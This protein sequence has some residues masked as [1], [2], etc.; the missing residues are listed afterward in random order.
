MKKLFS[1]IHENWGLESKILLIGILLI[2]LY[3][4]ALLVFLWMGNGYFDKLLSVG[5]TSLVFGRAAGISLALA[6]EVDF[7]WAM[8][9]NIYIENAL[10]LVVYPLFVWSVQGISTFKGGKKFFDSINKMAIKYEKPINKYG[11]FG[12][13]VF[14]WL[15]FW[16]TGPIVGAAIGY[17]MKLK[18]WVNLLVVLGGTNIAIFC[19]GY[20]LSH[21]D[22]NFKYFGENTI[23]VLLGVFI[24]LAL[25]GTIYTKFIKKG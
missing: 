14:V 15:P 17:F 8:V 16:M 20:L 10:V 18:V 24:S 21:L 23:W 11:I 4:V 3:L 13:F 7:A 6:L 2:L 22:S 12:L 1:L 5:F 25:L 19:W 9:I